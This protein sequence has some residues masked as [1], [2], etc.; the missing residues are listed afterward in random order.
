MPVIQSN[1]AYSPPIP[2]WTVPSDTGAGMIFNSFLFMTNY[3]EEGIP[4]VRTLVVRYD[5]CI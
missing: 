1:A 5:P 2:S 4:C 3:I